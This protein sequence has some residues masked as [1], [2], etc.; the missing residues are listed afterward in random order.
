MRRPKIEP[1]IRRKSWDGGD[2]KAKPK[3]AV[4]VGITFEQES[5]RKPGLEKKE[6]EE[7]EEEKEEKE[8][9]EATIAPRSPVK[10][11]C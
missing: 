5:G 1:H 10:P 8:G 7:E 3:E 11:L 4:S 9:Q 6:E 2:D